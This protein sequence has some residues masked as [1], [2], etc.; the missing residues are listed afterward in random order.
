MARAAADFRIS[1]KRRGGKTHRVEL[2]RIPF[3]KKFMVRTNGKRSADVP[4]AS[5]TEVAARVRRWLC[6]RV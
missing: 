6:G 5:A 3:T 4:T 1:R 2:L